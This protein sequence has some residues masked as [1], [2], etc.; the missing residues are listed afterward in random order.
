MANLCSV[1]NPELAEALE[2]RD[3]F[4]NDHPELKQLQR[5]IDDR[6]TKAVTRHN[7]LVVIHELMM[8]KFREL[9]T[10]LQALALKLRGS[11]S[12]V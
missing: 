3:R 6:L 10:K 1:T 8:D 11:R 7:R 2:Q 9:D 4:L 12:R 5:Q